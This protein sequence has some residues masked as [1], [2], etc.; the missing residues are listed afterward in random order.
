MRRF[1]PARGL[2]RA[3]R[4]GALAAAMTVLCPAAALALPDGRGWELVS[5]VDKNGGEIAVPGELFGGGVFQA[6][7][8]GNSV[9]YGSATSFGLAPA[10]APPGSQYLSARGAGGWATQNLNVPAFSGSYGADPDGVPYQLFSGD[11]SRALLLNGRH[12]RNAEAGCPVA[13]PP[14]AG[15]DAPAG[16]VN[17]YL[18][19]GAAGF[20]ALLGTADVAATGLGPA[21]FDLRLAGASPDLAHVVLESCAALTPGAAEVSLGG[22]CDPARPNLYGWSALGLRLLN[23]APGARLAAPANA[24]S[25]DGRRVYFVDSSGPGEPRLFLRDGTTS[26]Q[27]DDEAGGGGAFQAA[28]DDGAV[29]YFTKA[30]HLWRY[31]AATDTAADLTPAGEVLGVLGASADGSHVYYVASGGLHLWSGGVTTRVPTGVQVPTDASNF[32]PATGTARVSADGSRLV[33]LS[34]APLTGYDN[35]DAKTGLPGTQVFLYEAGADRLRCVSCRPNGSRPI[36]SST[37]PGAPANGELAGATV[38][39]KPRVLSA[40]GRWVFFDSDDSLVAGDVNREL[41]VYQWQATGGG[42]AKVNGC[43][44]L[45]S[46]GRSEGGARFIDASSSGADAF[47]VTDGSL[48]AAD[49]GSVDLYDARVGGGFPE[50]LLPIPCTGD[51]CQNLP[52]DPVDPGLNTLVTGPGNPKVRYFKYRRAQGCRGVAARKRARCQ[53]KGAAKGRGGSRGKGEKGKGGRR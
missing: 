49:P 14:L 45:I 6:A 30:G 2:R 11:L 29:A 46:S 26:K 37:I 33:F 43:I 48:V 40:D 47:F 24:I 5:P 12:C 32:P 9:T 28:G 20:E 36:G 7:A 16:Y 10:S 18:R 42:C 23:L 1:L 27:V 4:A 31:T 34:A 39:Y 22:G 50:P 3:V 41:D 25:A 38:S 51:A 19:Q 21:A 53:K 52:G 15:T 13:N 44:D 35:A 8:D 17:Y